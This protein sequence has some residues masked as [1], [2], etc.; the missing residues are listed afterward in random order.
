M[1]CP[2]SRASVDCCVTSPPYWG[3]R[4]AGQFG[5]ESTPA[6]YVA[7]LIEVFRL[8][9][10]ALRKNGTL[11]P[12]L[13][14]AYARSAGSDAGVNRRSFHGKM[15]AAGKLPCR[16]FRPPP[17]CKPKDLL[18]L[19]SQVAMALQA[20]GWFLRAEIVWHKPDP[21]PESCRDRPTRA[22]EFVYLLSKAG[23]YH[24]DRD[25]LRE[26]SGRNGLDV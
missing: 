15:A 18:L 25:A 14:D 16:A 21:N 7:R 8:V 17:G 3:Q 10:Q 6:E 11:W 19:P 1:S 5:L 2:G 23:R 4:D 26:P 22:H 24:F 12:V 20:D 9:R 13:G